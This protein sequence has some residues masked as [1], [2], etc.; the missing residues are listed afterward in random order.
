MGFA[1]ATSVS[2]GFG[3]ASFTIVNDTTITAVTPER[4]AP[5]TVDVTVTSASGTIL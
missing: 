5:G 1:E 3:F 2:V 4:A